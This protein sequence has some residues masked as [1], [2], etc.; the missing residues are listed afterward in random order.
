MPFPMDIYGEVHKARCFQISNTANGFVIADYRSIDD[1]GE[2]C[3][4]SVTIP[5]GVIAIHA[6]AFENNNLISVVIPSSVSSIGNNAFLG[7]LF[8]GWVYV[9]NPDV[10]VGTNAFPNGYIWGG[11][12]SI[13]LSN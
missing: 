4:R 7:N 2:A 12:Q 5:N 9:P 13:V 8:L 10:S 3:P 1:Y 11:T 6:N